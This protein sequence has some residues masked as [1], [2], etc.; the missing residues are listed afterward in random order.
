MSEQLLVTGGLGFLGSNFVRHAVAHTTAQ[1]TVVDKVS[2][3]ANPANLSGLPA[4]RVRVVRG[5]VEDSALMGVLAQRADTVVHFAAES[6]NDM[7]LHHPAAFISSNVQGTFSVLEA[8]RAHGC[9]LHHVSTDEVFGSITPSMGSVT[10]ASAYDPSSPYSA[11]KASSDLL[12][13]AWVRSFGVQATISNGTNVY[14][15]SQ[16]VEKFIPRQITH[17]IQDRRP[18]LYGDGRH[19]REWTHVADHNRAVMDILERGEVGESYLVGSGVRVANID[20]VQ[21]LL[22]HFDRPVDELDHITD[23]RGHD[24]RYAVDSR[25]LRALGWRPRFLSL[26]DGL[27]DTIDWYR[28]NECWWAEPKVAA[29]QRYARW[30]IDQKSGARGPVHD[31]T[32]S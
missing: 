9:R 6:H 12:V 28:Q 21:T 5:D 27:A 19:I 17:L 24:D 18:Q 14:G 7:A 20:V 11:S 32:T 15:P 2:Y 31:P 30:A 10:E 29:E 16:H 8:V 23:R 3:A 26:S 1:V 13:K 22:D 4:E 25:K